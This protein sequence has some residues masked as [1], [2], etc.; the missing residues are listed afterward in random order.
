MRLC[1]SLLAAAALTLPLSAGAQTLSVMR[2]EMSEFAFRPAKIHLTAGRPVRLVLV[3]R[4]QIAHQFE[5]GYL[6][7]LPVTMV[8]DTLHVEAPGLDVI[9]LDPGG[10]ARLEFLPRKKG[11]FVFFCAIEGHREAGMQGAME[12]R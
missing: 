12:V 8:S 4:G 6:R 11:H 2:I 10:T 3:N 9:R 7:T 1:I 5:T